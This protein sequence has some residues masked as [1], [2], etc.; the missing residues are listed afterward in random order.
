MYELWKLRDIRR[1]A[2]DT[3]QEIA[4]GKHVLGRQRANENVARNAEGWLVDLAD[5]ILMI[6]FGD[7]PRLDEAKTGYAGQARPILRKQP[8]IVSQD[9]GKIVEVEQ[10]NR[11]LSLGHAAVARLHDGDGRPDTVTASDIAHTCGEIVVVRA[12]A[13]PL[14]SAEDLGGVKGEDFDGA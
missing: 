3:R 13:A 12:N 9:G 6:R 1:S 11:R 4:P 2:V 5:H 10:P 14:G 7:V 8:V